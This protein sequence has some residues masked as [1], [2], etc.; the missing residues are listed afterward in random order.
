MKAPVNGTALG[1]PALRRK[2]ADLCDIQPGPWVPGQP[3]L[4]RET[5]SPKPK[6][7]KIG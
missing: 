7:K 6:A 4:R 5:P 3:R 2:Q 1:L